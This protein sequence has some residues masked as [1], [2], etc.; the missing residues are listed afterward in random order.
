MILDF[1]EIPHIV[2]GPE[3]TVCVNPAIFGQL[4]SRIDAE[5]AIMLFFA[6]G[7]LI[8]IGIMYLR[9]RWK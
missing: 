2:S 9:Q 1:P 3:G 6:A 5:H 8:G 7:M 4:V